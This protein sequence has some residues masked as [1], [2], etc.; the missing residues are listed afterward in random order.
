VQCSARRRRVAVV[1]LR[2]IIAA[3]GLLDA[4]RRIAT[5][6]PCLILR[7]CTQAIAIAG[8][9]YSYVKLHCYNHVLMTVRVGLE[10]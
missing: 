3:A 10:Q 9:S 4:Q 1:T 5:T 8:P 2:L 6:P 7:F